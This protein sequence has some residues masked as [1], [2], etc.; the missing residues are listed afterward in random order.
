MTSDLPELSDTT[1]D[2]LESQ[3]NKPIKQK[4][5]WFTLF[6]AWTALFFTAIGIMAGYKN[7]LRIHDKTKVNKSSIE[8][9]QNQLAAV[10]SNKQLNS[11]RTELLEKT[12][13][14]KAQSSKALTQTQKYAQQSQ[15]Y[16]ETIDAQVAEMTQMQARLQ[17]SAKPTTSKD[18]VL[19]ETEFLLRMANRQL[20]LDNDK[21]SALVALRAADEN[22][23]R[24]GSPHY[25]PVRQQ[26]TKDITTLEQYAAPKITELSQQITSLMI[27]LKPLPANNQDIDEGEK[28]VLG[29]NTEASADEKSKNNSLWTEVKV[30][31]QD[32]FKEAVVIRKHNQPIESDL[33]TDSRLQLYNLVQLRLETLRLM[34]LQGLNKEFHQQ[35]QLINTTLE[36]YY[37]EERAK[38]LLDSMKELDKHNLSPKKPDISASMKQ[39]ESALLTESSKQTSTKEG[40]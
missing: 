20:H 40:K 11:I 3:E 34:L 24:L 35:I 28:L 25:L 39:L 12:E 21:Q 4:R 2:T 18:W 8:V 27:K 37:P 16:A 23:A 33:D 14:V 17:L 31:A 29:S 10:P 7:W 5:H 13:E 22:L 1:D 6:I 9:I 30:Q 26:I 15:H 38:P 32:A 36:Q 19:S